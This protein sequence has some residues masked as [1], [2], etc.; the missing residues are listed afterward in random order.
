LEVVVVVVIVAIVVVEGKLSKS[1]D[2]ALQ[3]NFHGLKD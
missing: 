1:E 2:I 3:G